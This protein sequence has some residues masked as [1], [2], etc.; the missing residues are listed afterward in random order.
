MRS[1]GSSGSLGSAAARLLPRLFLPLLLV[2]FAGV[3]GVKV[4]V[5]GGGGGLVECISFGCPCVDTTG[6]PVGNHKICPV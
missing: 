5:D 2:L 4:N 1:V 6:T 3:G